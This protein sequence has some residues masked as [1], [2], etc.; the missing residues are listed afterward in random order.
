MLL[1]HK[2]SVVLILGYFRLIFYIKTYDNLIKLNILLKIT[3]VV[4]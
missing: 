2:I 4:V 1:L 3:P